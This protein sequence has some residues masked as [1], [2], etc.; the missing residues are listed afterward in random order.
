MKKL[1][2]FLLCLIFVI[3]SSM[4]LTGCASVFD[5][6]FQESSLDSVL[7]VAKKI[8]EVEESKHLSMENGLSFYLYS[9]EQYTNLNYTLTMNGKAKIKNGIFRMA[10]TFQTTESFYSEKDAVSG[11]LYI[12]N[13]YTLVDF[14]HNGVEA[15]IKLEQNVL[16]D[17][18]I[19]LEDFDTSVSFCDFLQ[20]LH[21]LDGDLKLYLENSVETGVKIKIE[22][23]KSNYNQ[24]TLIL[25]CDSEYAITAVR[26]EERDYISTIS[27]TT[28]ELTPYSG[29]VAL[30]DDLESY[31]LITTYQ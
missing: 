26:I 25:V 6:N 9:T 24:I 22:Y 27:T 15:K 1:L 28:L 10:G 12:Y 23:A 8:D 19:P 29:T 30:P 13:D 4:L 7:S 31:Q 20:T 14:T 18:D 17:V 11:N 2:T 21:N 5:G 3:S 16:A